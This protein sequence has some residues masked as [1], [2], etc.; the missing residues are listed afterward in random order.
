[1]EA[2]FAI[3]T[4]ATAREIYAYLP[5]NYVL[6]AW[7]PLGDDGLKTEYLIG[8]V[9]NAGWTLDEYVV[10]RFASGSIPARQIEATEAIEFFHATRR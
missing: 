7:N 9:D 8:G 5:D 2:K 3:V 4:A 1:M 6:M 10:P